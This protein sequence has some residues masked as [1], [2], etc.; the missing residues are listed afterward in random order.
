MAV[1]EFPRI[2]EV[3]D[4]MVLSA[5]VLNDYHR[6]LQF[7]LG[8]ARAP[9]MC[10][11]LPGN[12]VSIGTGTITTA[13]GGYA[14]AIGPTLY[15]DF[16]VDTT[17]AGKSWWVYVQVHNGTSWTTLW[18]AS[19]NSK[20]HYANTVSIA[21]LTAGHV[22]QFRIAAAA[23]G[24]GTYNVLVSPVA[25]AVRPSLTGWV[26]PPAF[27]A[28]TSHAADLNKV[29]T[30]LNALYAWTSRWSAGGL[31][32]TGGGAGPWWY[33]V[34]RCGVRWKAG[35]RLHTNIELRGSLASGVDHWCEFA[36]RGVRADGVTE[37]TLYTSPHIHREDLTNGGDWTR[38]DVDDLQ[39]SGL[40]DGA[41]G[42]LFWHLHVNL[43]SDTMQTRRSFAHRV[44]FLAP[45]TG[46]PT[47]TDWVH[48][49]YVTSARLN[50]ISTGLTALYSGVEV[51]RPEVP[52]VGGGTMGFVHARPWL[53][54][55]PAGDVSVA[56]GAH[57]GQTYNLPG[58]GA[59]AN[60]DLSQ[61][62]QFPY[63]SRYILTGVAWA[64]EADE[65]YGG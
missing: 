12:A 29:R 21:G 22:Y 65:V 40:A 26:S 37:D 27:A 31:C 32:S 42:Q 45:Q 61:I 30:D 52:V 16:W 8:Q 62:R 33:V 23:D 59:V 13:L 51:L 56:Y 43:S 10:Q 4:G 38:F 14:P 64:F 36:I 53:V 7:L 58:G 19:G 47:L 50:A 49:D 48:G 28:G 18:S 15:Y 46:W 41:Y 39:W 5:S 60:F 9:E 25:L 24:T 2:T 6:G 55:L 54:Y 57:Y 35:Q 17:W 1:L 11:R 3:Q 34:G 20:T 63:G 44:C